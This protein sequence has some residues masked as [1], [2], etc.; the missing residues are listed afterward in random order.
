MTPTLMALAAD[1]LDSHLHAGTLIRWAWVG[2]DAEGRATAC[3]LAA[4]S[5]ECGVASS[6][7]ACPAVAIDAEVTDAL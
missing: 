5:P 2:T 1:R 4:L 6:A 3:L 7:A